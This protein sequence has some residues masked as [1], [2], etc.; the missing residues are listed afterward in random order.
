MKKNLTIFLLL[1][2]LSSFCQW[3]YK[4]FDNEFDGDYKL[5]WVIGTG[6]EYPYNNAHLNIISYKESSKIDIYISEA[7]YSGCSNL[8]LYFTFDEN[9]EIYVSESVNSGNNNDAWFLKR[10]KK[11]QISQLLENF[12][13]HNR[14]SVRVGSSCGYKDYRFSLKG[15]T[16]AI[17]YV[18]RKEYFIKQKERE[19]RRKKISA[20]NNKIEDS[21]NRL[22][23]IK[24]NKI[25]SVFNAKKLKRY[26]KYK[27]IMDKYSESK[28]KFYMSYQK[29]PLYSGFPIKVLNIYYSETNSFF[30]VDKSFKNNDYVKVVYISKK[31]SVEYYLPSFKIPREISREKVNEFINNY[32]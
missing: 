8:F 16:K 24:K 23:K 5:G 19:L 11:I 25:D 18:V 22:N 21:I 32:E 4:S 14:V 28:Y 15:A 9:N 10:L 26:I 29:L 3:N 31:G 12:K 17:N 20:K 13:K 27:N 7:G 2:S 30:V 1:I 6:G